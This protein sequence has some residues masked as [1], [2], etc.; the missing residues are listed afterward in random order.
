MFQCA[1]PVDRHFSQKNRK[2]IFV[3]KKTGKPFIGQNKKEASDKK[4][5]VEVLQLLKNRLNIVDPIEE[6]VQVV[7]TFYFK[8][9]YTKKGLRSKKLPDQSNL[10]QGPEDA[11]QAAG[12]IKDDGQ[13]MSHDGSRRLPGDSNILEITI[14]PFISSFE[15]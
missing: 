6:D 1:I 14:Y 8:D 15:M 7:F 11:L 2:G 10:Y 13:I 3:N 9:Y 12:I 4:Y 5:L